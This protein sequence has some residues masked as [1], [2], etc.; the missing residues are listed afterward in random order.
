[1]GDSTDA[2][3]AAELIPLEFSDISG[4]PDDDHAAAFAAFRR[5]AVASAATIRRRRA[6]SASTP[7]RSPPAWR[8]PPRFPKPSPPARPAPSSRRHSAPPRWCRQTAAASSPAITSRRWRARARRTAQFTVPLL[9]PPDDLVEFDPADPP[10]GLD[11]ALRFAR[12]T[13]GGYAE[14]P[15]RAAIMAGALAGRGL[16][17]VWLAD[18]VDAFFIHIQGAARIRLGRRQHAPRH[19][20]RQDRPPLH[21]DRPGADRARRARSPAPPPCRRSA[22]GSPAIRT[23]PPR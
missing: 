4:W 19:L 18:P 23:R 9:A 15:D 3:G 6:A 11:P 13:A 21:A 5:S 7:Q 14:Y 1:M 16:E 22:P 17:L 12:K 10:P 20:R 8:A 2:V